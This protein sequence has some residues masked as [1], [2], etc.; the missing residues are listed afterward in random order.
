[1]CLPYLKSLD[2]LPETHSL[3][4][5]SVIFD[6][7]VPRERHKPLALTKRE[8]CGT[9][10]KLPQKMKFKRPCDPV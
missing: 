2:P 10:Y 8:I 6:I 1:M 7:I 4:D 9:V 5:D 3:T